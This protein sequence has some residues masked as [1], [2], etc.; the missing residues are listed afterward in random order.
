MRLK[1]LPVFLVFLLTIFSLPAFSEDDNYDRC[2]GFTTPSS[3]P[4]DPSQ[5][6]PACSPDF[7]QRYR[8]VC[9]WQHFV[10]DP[11]NGE[12]VSDS[13][14]RE[15]CPDRTECHITDPSSPNGATCQPITNK[16]AYNADATQVVEYLGDTRAC[17]TGVDCPAGW[18]CSTTS[19]GQQL[20]TK[21]TT[22]RGFCQG[23]SDCKSNGRCDGNVATTEGYACVEGSCMVV[24]EIV[25]ECGVD[26][27]TGDILTCKEKTEAG[28]TIASC[29]LESGGAPPQPLSSNAL[30]GGGLLVALL[31]AGYAVSRGNP[32]SSKS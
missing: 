3:C 15:N 17:S 1:L 13:V 31:L 18:S 19:S 2:G 24:A 27:V 21:D 22:E 20:C 4:S 32:Q 29:E 12:C 6:L 23:D 28:G 9:V 8:S 26:H 16:P 7:K 25:N 11:E 30:I 10:G 14:F 5:D